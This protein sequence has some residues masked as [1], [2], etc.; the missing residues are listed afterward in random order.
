MN[1]TKS[2]WYPGLRLFTQSERGNW[3]DVLA[4]VVAALQ[5]EFMRQAR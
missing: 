5:E 3:D 2:P 4:R 1:G